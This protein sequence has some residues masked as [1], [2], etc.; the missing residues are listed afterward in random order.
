VA[1]GD[2]LRRFLF[3]QWPVRGHFVRLDASWRAVIE[4]H[5]YPPVLTRVLGEALAATVLVAGTIKFKGQLSLQFQG[6]GPA[7]LILAQCS[8]RLAVRAVARYD[9]ELPAA[10]TLADVTGGGQLAVTLD[11]EQSG[12]RYQGV[13]PLAGP[14]LAS[15]L[16]EYFLRSEQ[17]PSRLV[18]AASGEHAAGLLLQRVAAGAGASIA[19]DPRALAA[20]EDAWRRIGLLAATLTPAELLR[21]PCENLLYRLFNEDDVRLFEGAPVFF[22]CSCSRGRV[23]GILRSLGEAEVR[24]ILRERGDVE[25]HCEFCNRA[26]LFDAVDALTLF[27]A[28]SQPG[29]APGVH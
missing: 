20:A 24:D 14:D 5:D 18:L 3:E 26:Y 17:L 13:V 12:N 28:G 27:A 15:C 2:L 8:D 19:E 1:D 25:V 23:S 10:A 6:P 9:G 7:R 11:N 29:A 21:L 22:Q 4:H 16:E